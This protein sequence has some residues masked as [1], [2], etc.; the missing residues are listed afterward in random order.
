MVRPRQREFLLF[1]EGGG[2]EGVEASFY[3]LLCWWATFF[4]LGGEG[5]YKQILPG[6][7]KDPAS[8]LTLGN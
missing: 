3:F 1:W 5:Q 2:G 6:V 7:A 4:I 8:P